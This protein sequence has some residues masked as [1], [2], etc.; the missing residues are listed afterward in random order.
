[1]RAKEANYCV[2]LCGDGT[3]Y[4]LK[5]DIS[6][7]DAH[8]FRHLVAE[9]RRMLNDER[10][11]DLLRQALRLWQGPAITSIAPE[12]TRKGWPGGLEEVR[13]IALEDDIASELRL[14]RHRELL[15]ELIELV[16]TSP[17]RSCLLRD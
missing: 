15:D 12:C 11:A 7:I 4:V 2:T 17:L 9:A 14:G 1:M 3:A 13:L 8:Y 16:E 6:F 5:A 10:K